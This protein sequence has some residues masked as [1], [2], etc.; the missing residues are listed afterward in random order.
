MRAILIAALL[1]LPGVIFFAYSSSIHSGSFDWRYFA[2]NY[3]WCAGI[4]YGAALILAV[5]RAK[6]RTWLVALAAGNIALLGFCL[7][8]A[9]LLSR[10]YRD[11]E[12][13]WMLLFPFQ[14]FT[15]AVACVANISLSRA[16]NS[17]ASD[18]G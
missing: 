16:S 18:V 15:M 12:I 17:Q 13:A 7:W 11:T 4:L 1:G 9:C 10:G 3:A 6:F 8:M 2:P 14:V 5:M